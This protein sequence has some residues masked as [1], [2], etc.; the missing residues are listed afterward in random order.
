MSKLGPLDEGWERLRSA[1]SR[2]DGKPKEDWSPGVDL[3]ELVLI[4]ALIVAVG[5]MAV[6]VIA[7]L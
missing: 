6:G 2:N 7:L 1:W 5:A 3:K 4:G